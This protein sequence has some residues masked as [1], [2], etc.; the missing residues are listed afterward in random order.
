MKEKN[1]VKSDS[2]D[3]FWTFAYRRQRR[4]LDRFNGS[5]LES[6]DKILDT[7]KF[8]NCYRALDR[9]SQYLI[10]HI[11]NNKSFSPEDTFLRIILFKLF[12][13]IETWEALQLEIGEISLATFD[14]GKIS[15]LLNAR[16][17]VGEK[18]YS[19]AYIMPSGKKEFGSGT[20]HINNLLMVDHM[21]KKEMH[22]KIWDAST[23]EDIYNL[24]HEIPSI[25]NFL[26][27]QYSIDFC[28]SSYSDCQEAQFIIA[29][30]GAIRGIQ[31]CFHNVKP[32]QYSCII[33]YM[34]DVQEEEFKRLNLPFTPLKNRNLQLIDCQNLFCETDKYLRVKKPYLDSRPSR[35]KQK[36]KPNLNKIDFILP[37]KWNAEIQS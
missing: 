10:R 7:Y 34:S 4:F 24:F 33:R 27:F 32:N 31:K 23:L 26:A 1:L 3:E 28:Y 29:G 13:K 18:I 20:K 5:T 35:I 21:L 2:Y 37:H 15:T 14:I 9:T 16:R 25:G 12:N 36:F 8:T 6:N 11:T 30:P 19:A 22:R 17:N